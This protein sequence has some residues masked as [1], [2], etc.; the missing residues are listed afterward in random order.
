MIRGEN[1]GTIEFDL[2]VRNGTIL[3]LKIFGDY[4]SKYDTEEIESALIGIAH[5]EDDLREALKPFN[6]DD[7]FAGLT[8]KELIDGMF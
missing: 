2:D 4:F 7:Y 1:S 5:N 8:V 6:I 3:H